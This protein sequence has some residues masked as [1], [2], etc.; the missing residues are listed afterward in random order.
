MAHSSIIL[1]V[2]YAI[3]D[4][5]AVAMIEASKGCGNIMRF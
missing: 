4:R 5:E 3:I 2:V 1:G